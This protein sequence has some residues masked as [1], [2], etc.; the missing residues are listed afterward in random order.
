MTPSGTICMLIDSISRSQDKRLQLS[1]SEIS[2]LLASPVVHHYT[3]HTSSGFTRWSYVSTDFQWILMASIWFNMISFP[4]YRFHWMYITTDSH[5]SSCDFNWFLHMIIRFV[6]FL[7]NLFDMWIPSY[8]MGFWCIFAKPQWIFM[9]CDI[10]LLC[11]PLEPHW[12][13]Y[14]PFDFHE[15]FMLR[16]TPLLCK[17]TGFQ[18]IS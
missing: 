3:W 14:T 6:C 12:I 8:F 1:F 7:W 4:F 17:S 9:I 16:D 10:F 5:W 18:W 13:T 11:G 2:E 15:I